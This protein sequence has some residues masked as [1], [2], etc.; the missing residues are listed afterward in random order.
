MINFQA[1][2]SIEMVI[3]ELKSFQVILDWS[4]SRRSGFELR[5]NGVTT[6]KFVALEMVVT[7]ITKDVQP[8]T[9]KSSLILSNNHQPPFMNQI[10][11]EL[12]GFPKFQMILFLILWD[13][14]IKENDVLL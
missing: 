8:L 2:I 1:F 4:L 10:W 9:E 6:L 13:M 7:Y 11:V 3:L 5:S 14:L 12:F